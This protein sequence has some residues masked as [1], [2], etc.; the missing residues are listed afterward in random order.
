MGHGDR[1]LSSLA[2]T[3]V[4]QRCGIAAAL[5]TS[6]PEVRRCPR[7]APLPVVEHDG[8][9]LAIFLRYIEAPRRADQVRAVVGQLMDL[10]G[11]ERPQLEDV[12]GVRLPR[13]ADPPV[14]ALEESH[15]E[16][17][18]PIRCDGLD[19]EVLQSAHDVG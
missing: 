19:A 5:P 1:W 12:R 4:A 14:D 6:L 2:N 13:A 17:E 16:L 9:P 7:P 15:L 10:G 11:D 8:R 18:Q 3:A